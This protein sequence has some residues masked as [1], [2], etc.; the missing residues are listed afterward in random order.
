MSDLMSVEEYA[1]R[2]GCSAAAVRKAIRAGRIDAQK[3]G[4]RYV[5]DPAAADRDWF[6]RTDVLRTHAAIE[7]AEAQP[8]EPADPV[9][10]AVRQVIN[11]ALDLQ[12][13]IE[14]GKPPMLATALVVPLAALDASPHAESDTDHLRRKIR[15][16]IAETARAAVDWQAAEAKP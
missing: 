8:S 3:D 10:Q 7:P 1:E 16:A 6:E 11:E 5:I 2:R 14:P 4:R 13:E 12:V 15:A 9:E